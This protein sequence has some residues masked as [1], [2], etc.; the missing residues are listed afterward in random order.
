[1][2]TPFKTLALKLYIENKCKKKHYFYGINIDL[3]F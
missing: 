1:M 3:Q 2:K